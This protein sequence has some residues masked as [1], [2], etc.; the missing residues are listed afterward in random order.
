M[1][2]ALAIVLALTSAFGSGYCQSLHAA[3]QGRT[4]TTSA[5]PAPSESQDD[6]LGI[7]WVQIQ[8]MGTATLSAAVVSPRGRGPFP[9]IVIL[10][11]SHGFAKE[12]VDL[13]RSFA[14]SGFV[15]VAGCWFS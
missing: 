8:V 13:A 3:G 2:T 12:Y 14:R 5:T 4:D 15:A 11:G 6:S 1:R 10:H 7:R 9:A